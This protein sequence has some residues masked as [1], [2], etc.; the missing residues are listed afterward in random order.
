MD[1]NLRAFMAIA[2]DRNLTSAAKVLGITQPSLTKRLNNLEETLGCRLF[3]RHRRGMSLTAEG[4]VMMRRGT[5]IEQEYLQAREELKGLMHAG[6]EVLRI[7]A[8]PLFHLRYVAP[9]Y[10]WTRQIYPQLR[11]DLVAD[12]NSRTLPLLIDGRLD[13]VLGAIE[14]VN[15]DHLISVLPMVQV[16][17]SVVLR[18]DD[19]LADNE[20]LLPPQ[21]KQLTWVA[22]SEPRDNRRMLSDYFAAHNLGVPDFAVTTSA[23]STGLDIVRCTGFAMMAPLQL[24][25]SIAER[26]LRA[27]PASPSICPLAAGAY[28]R[29]ST[30]TIPAVRAFLGEVER[31][32]LSTP[33]QNEPTWLK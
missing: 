32:I 12:N 24:A 5:R 1:K 15:P 14:P 11:L 7:G 26:G 25:S 17:Q 21:I 2:K 10:A 22:Y 6:T 4:I 16:E 27:I 3:V 33:G 9:A 28:L 31:E 29:E 19:P 20:V 8:G 23:F 18:Q 13:L 30:R